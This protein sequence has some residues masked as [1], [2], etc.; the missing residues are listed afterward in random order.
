MN[1]LLIMNVQILGLTDDQK[2][3]SVLIQD[4]RI[5]LFDPTPGQFDSGMTQ[6]D[7]GGRLLTAG[8]I[9]LHIHGIEKWLF[10]SG[11][12][13]LVQGV[14]A[15]AKYGVT[16]VLPT[17]Y[18][19]MSEDQFEV[20]S[21]LSDALDNS[22][23]VNVPGF[24]LEGP[25]LKLAGAGA[26]THDGDVAYLDRLIEAAQ[27]KIS[28]MSISPDTP[29]VLPVIRHLV[30]QGF[31]VFMTHTQ[32]DVDQTLAAIDAGARHATHFYDVFPAPEITEAGVRPVGCVETILADRNVSV[33]F[34]AD[35]VHAHPMAIKMALAAKGN[36]GVILITDANIGAGLGEG[37]YDTPWGF[38]VR[39]HE[40]DAARIELP[41]ESRH[42]SLAGSA[43]TMPQGIANLRRW[44]D[45]PEDQVWAMGSRNP[46]RRM[47]W[48][49]KGVLALGA[50]AD[51][52]IWDDDEQGLRPNKTVVGGRLIYEAGQL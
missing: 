28:A 2:Q 31:V 1:D 44:L 46:A 9:D 51:L 6:V 20:L 5:V 48:E 7:G 21:T 30:K 43:L 42:G 33:D 36:D 39:V 32:A 15:L 12:N 16:T 50:D 49:N 23:D 27:G 29:G 41:G 37:V 34:I 17:L 45:V 40:G 3:H 13:A 47:G 11:P 14:N 35:G 52:V 25:F 26:Q 19:V 10:E 24:H 4:G 22:L 8:L 18:R 38:A